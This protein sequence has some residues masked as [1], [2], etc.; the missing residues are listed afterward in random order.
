MVETLIPG[1]V[2]DVAELCLSRV[3]RS[4]FR[5]I[6]QVCWGW[7]RFLWSERY[8]AVRKLTGSVEEL[9]CVLMDHQ[10]WEVFDGSGNKLGG[11]PP[12][13]GPLKRDSR[14]AMLDGG[15]I[16]VIGA[17]YYKGRSEMK[18]LPYVYEFNPCTNRKLADMNIPRYGFEYAVVDGLLYVIRGLTSYGDYL[19][20]LE[21]YNPKTNK[22]SLMDF[23]YRPTSYCAFAFSFKSKL[24][25]AGENYYKSSF[26]YIYDPKTETWEE[27]DSGYSIKAYSYTVIRNKVCFFDCYNYR[28]MVV[29]DPEKNSWSFVFLPQ[30]SD[31]E[32]GFRFILGKLNNKVFLVS[33]DG[34]GICSDDFDKEDAVEWKA[35]P[36]KLPA[37][38]FISSVLINF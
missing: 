13:P 26:I 21:V 37:Y 7:R 34:E 32:S 15:K 35:S 31:H 6:C 3:P 10:Y 29:F 20:N 11:I 27:F 19:F 17:I 2:D 18:A 23:P 14:L 1:L 25:V 22:W 38:T 30:F 5:I 9:M 36:I 24:F 33:Q 8:G 12:I 16:V 4:S 28:G